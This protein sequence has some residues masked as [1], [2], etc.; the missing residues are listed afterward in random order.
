MFNINTQTLLP[1]VGYSLILIFLVLGGVIVIGIMKDRNKNKAE[2]DAADGTAGSGTKVKATKVKGATKTDKK[3]LK[4][5]NQEG[6]FTSGNKKASENSSF[7]LGSDARSAAD[8]E[9]SLV[10]LNGARSVN[11]FRASSPDD[12]IKPEAKPV[13]QKPFRT[14]AP[15]VQETVE[16]DDAPYVPEQ[17]AVVTPPPVNPAAR[18]PPAPLASFTPPKGLPTMPPRPDMPNKL[19]AP[20]ALKAAPQD[21]TKQIFVGKTKESEK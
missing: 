18:K 3:N 9:D 19:G 13:E 7:A 8:I 12:L 10:S 21:P 2:A 5:E 11:R 15:A 17:P 16:P 14:F 1:I 20:P 4:K 6:M